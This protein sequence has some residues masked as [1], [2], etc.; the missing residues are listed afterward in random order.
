V[1]HLR[2]KTLA[3]GMRGAIFYESAL[4]GAPAAHN[5]Q[6]KT[7]RVPIVQ[8]P[9]VAFAF[10]YHEH[11]LRP[12]TSDLPPTMPK[13]KQRKSQPPA[14]RLPLWQ[15]GLLMLI[16]GPASHAVSTMVWPLKPPLTAEQRGQAAGR[17]AAAIAIMIAGV[18]VLIVHFVKQRRR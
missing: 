4:I 3:V 14:N 7:G 8:R 2:P 1:Q 18:V 12:P 9:D 15:I 6:T 16:A 13:P 11:S 17:A 5:T 10:E